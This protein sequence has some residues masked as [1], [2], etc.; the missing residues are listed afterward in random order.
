MKRYKGPDGDRLWFADG[1]IDAV[2]ETELRK[3]GLMPT[4]DKPAVDIEAFIERHLKAQLD[5]YADLDPL[6]LGETEFRVG[7]PPLVSINKDLT[8]E[9]LD[10]DESPPGIRGRWRATAAHEAGHVIVHACLFD[11]NPGQQVLFAAEDDA[12]PKAKRLQRCLRRDVA[13]RGGGDW[14]EIQA[15]MCMAALLMPGPL[16]AAAFTQEVGR[17]GMRRV[18]RGS[19][20]VRQLAAALAPRFEVS[21]QAAAIRMETLALLAQP[22]QADIPD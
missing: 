14:R 4:L 1:E 2:M 11:L 9:A 15:N 17:L 16:F 21:K 6:T 3:A 5:H 13:H 22:G 7:A 20:N 8:A 19:G 18:E 12:A 10:D